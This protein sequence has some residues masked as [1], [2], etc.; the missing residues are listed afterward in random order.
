MRPTVWVTLLVFVV[1]AAGIRAHSS[2]VRAASKTPT[3]PN[4]TEKVP[5]WIVTGKWMKSQQDAI[6]SAL[7]AARGELA[8][9][10]RK[11][12]PRVEYVPTIDLIRDHL[13][14]DLRLEDQPRDGA[15]EVRPIERSRKQMFEEE[16]DF[17]GELG[18]MRRV[19]LKA[20]LTPD[21]LKRIKAEDV[22]YRGEQRRLV[23][24]GRQV[25]LAKVLAAVVALL[26]VLAGYFRLEEATKGYYT[27]ALRVGA[28]AVVAA[29]VAGL[30]LLA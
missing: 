18:I 29:V 8:A 24:Q 27:T 14:A 21:Q 28:F 15:K 11:Q 17:Q 20:T 5:S 23:S 4:A 7:E 13:L 16:R 30:W 19:S 1:L 6:D 26:G 22:K 10:L 25:L 3:S 2:S 12:E 9:Y